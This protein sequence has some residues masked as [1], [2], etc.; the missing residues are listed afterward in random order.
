MKIISTMLGLLLCIAGG[1][2]AQEVDPRMKKDLEVMERIVKEMFNSSEPKFR[3]DAKA[4][5]T[6]GYGIVISTPSKSY[7]V[8]A[9]A[10]RT[11]NHNGTTIITRKDFEKRD[12]RSGNEGDAVEDL[13]RKFISSYGDLASGL[14][15]GEK[16]LMVYEQGGSSR[17]IGIYFGEE[18][19]ETKITAMVTKEDL[20]SFR[21]GSLSENDFQDKIEV[22]INDSSTG[23]SAFEY[24]MLGNILRD[25]LG[26]SSEDSFHINVGDDDEDEKRVVRINGFGRKARVTH[27]VLDGYGVTYQ[28]KLPSNQIMSFRTNGRGRVKKISKLELE[29]DENGEEYEKTHDKHFMDSYSNAQSEIKEA[30][31]EYGRTLRDMD[32]SEQLIVKLDMGGCYDCDAPAEVSFQ[33]KK[34]VLES[35][36]RREI[37]LD[38]AIAQIKVTE[39]GKASDVD[40]RLPFFLDM[41]QSNFKFNFDWDEEDWDWN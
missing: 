10:V 33:V 12:G 32:A 11:H 17:D 2:S 41:D 14:Q 15:R 40:I 7:E 26:E 21:K 31:I 34:S 8:F 29:E 4:E 25:I 3:G 18:S 23:G 5:Y 37:D 35:Y 22:K 9:P 28:L 36:D 13:M 38:K 6:E 1:L 20:E 30:M 19:D 27:Q 16:L 39:S 24:K